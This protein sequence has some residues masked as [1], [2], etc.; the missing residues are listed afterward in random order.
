[1]EQ[2]IPIICP[3]CGVG[4]NLELELNAD[5]VPK[6]CGATG[7]NPDLNGR[8]AC[9]K[10][11]A[12]TDLYNHPD[13]LTQPLLREN[14]RLVNTDWERAISTASDKLQAIVKTYGADSI[15]MLVSGKI[16]NEEVYLSQKFQR[17]VIGNNHVDNCARL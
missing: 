5:G 7:R 11:F 9:V 16:T 4:C 3:Y 14:G 2:S 15:G 17:V 10:G 12:V 8:Y 6:K 13:R 1:M